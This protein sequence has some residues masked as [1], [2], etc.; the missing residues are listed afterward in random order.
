MLDHGRLVRVRLQ[1]SELSLAARLLLRGVG[2]RTGRGAG[3]AGVEAEGSDTTTGLRV[4]QE[5]EIV[6]RSLALGESA[7]DVSPAT[8]LLVAVRELDVGVRERV[9]GV[10]KS[11]P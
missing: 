6:Q 1:A 8:L 11:S 7:Q 5:L 4:L 9:A 10:S 2:E 3:E